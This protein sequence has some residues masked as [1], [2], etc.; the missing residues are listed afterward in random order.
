MKIIMKNDISEEKK[1]YFLREEAS[2]VIV[3][4]GMAAMPIPLW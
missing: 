3:I 2:R 4:F 1:K